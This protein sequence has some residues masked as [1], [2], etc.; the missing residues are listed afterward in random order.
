MKP[1]KVVGLT[2]TIASGKSSAAQYLKEAY[3]IPCIDADLVGHE[4]LTEE[5][6]I[7]QLCEA[8]GDGILAEDG[9]VSRK[10]LGELVFADKEKLAVLNQITHPVICRHIEEWTKQCRTEAPFVLIEAYGL[11][12]SDLKDLADE[13]WV[14]GC[15]KKLRINRVMERQHLSLEQA[16][17]RVAG[18]WPDEKYREAADVYLDGSGTLAFLEA[19]CDQIMKRYRINQ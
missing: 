6:V 15:D 16:Q 7:K 4:V 8:F 19:Q 12:Q 5:P 10:A 9:T 11:L 18:Q 2:G 14:V 3:Q 13:V 17:A 1:N